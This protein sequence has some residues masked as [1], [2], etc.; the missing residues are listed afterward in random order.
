MDRP[1]AAGAGDR[2]LRPACRPRRAGPTRT[3]T[4]LTAVSGGSM[5]RERCYAE[6]IAYCDEHDIGTYGICLRGERTGALEKTGQW[7]ESA[8]LSVELLTGRQPRRSTGSTRCEPG[9][10]PGAPGRAPAPGSTWTRR[11]RPRTAPASRSG[12]S[13]PGW[14]APRRTG[15]RAEPDSAAREAELADDVVRPGRRL[16]PRGGRCLA[17][18]HGLDPAAARGAGRALPAAGRRRLGEGR[19]A[20]AGPGLPVRGRAGP[21]RRRRR[22]RRCAGR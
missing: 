14:P 4:P 19:A 15:W 1:D 7:E 5:R 18:A 16:G 9:Q 6:G 2:G 13:R 20:V 10:D 8:S 12:S 3:C 21:V 11:R 17:A 22:R